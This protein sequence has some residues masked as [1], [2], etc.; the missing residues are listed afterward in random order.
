MR[1]FSIWTPR[2][3]GQGSRAS[4]G[5]RGAAGVTGSAIEPALLSAIS[6]EIASIVKDVDQHT[7][8]RHFEICHL[9]I[10]EI[11]EG[12]LRLRAIEREGTRNLHGGEPPLMLHGEAQNLRVDRLLAKLHHACFR[13]TAQRSA[14]QRDTT[15]GRQRDGEDQREQR[16]RRPQT[17]IGAR[18]AE[19]HEGRDQQQGGTSNLATHRNA[20]CVKDERSGQGGIRTH[21]TREGPPVF[22]TGSFN[23]SDTCPAAT[24]ARCR[25]TGRVWKIAWCAIR[26]Y[27]ATHGVRAFDRCLWYCG[28][29]QRRQ[30]NA[31]PFARN[32]MI[33]LTARFTM[34]EGMVPGALALV[35]AVRVE[36][37]E[38][39]PGTLMYLI[40]RALDKQYQPT[41]DLVFSTCCHNPPNA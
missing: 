34:K 9:A 32:A 15:R 30:D 7:L 1:T 39:Q 14:E 2:Q 27:V 21:E 4:N 19:Q 20:S 12:A 35:D 31:S 41:L 24:V 8:V 13:V 37:D 22:K 29:R 33:T 25:A 36:S 3:T 28:A 6:V 10:H 5:A 26:R 11:V 18:E 38:D 40:H 23:H 16:G 17:R